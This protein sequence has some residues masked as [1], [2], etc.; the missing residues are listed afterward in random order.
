ML[1]QFFSVKCLEK[2]T[3]RV[4]YLG[5]RPGYMQCEYCERHFS[6]TA[7]ERH[8]EF[9]KEQKNR[10]IQPQVDNNALTRLM[11]RSVN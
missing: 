5:P 1:S 7:A 2:T 10:L 9:C 4:K 11:A 3:E 6:K 8:I